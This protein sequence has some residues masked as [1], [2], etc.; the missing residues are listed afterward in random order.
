MN[1]GS[2]LFKE[3][4]VDKVREHH[5]LISGDRLQSDMLEDFS[6]LKSSPSL[7]PV[8]CM[9][10]AIRLRSFRRQP[11]ARVVVAIST[12]P[13]PATTLYR[14]ETHNSPEG[15]MVEVC[16]RSSM[17]REHEESNFL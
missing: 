3:G 8:C 10:A 9:A 13:S 11:S 2:R 16:A 5:T 1:A 12:R 15:P 6:S 4:M 14:S 7:I 17:S